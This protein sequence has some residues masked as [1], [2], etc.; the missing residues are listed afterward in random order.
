MSL[1][2]LSPFAQQFVSAISLL[3][4]VLTSSEPLWWTCRESSSRNSLL[5]I[6][7]GEKLKK[8]CLET[9]RIAFNF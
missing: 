4:F 9:S 5:H 7:E 6:A 8:R 3:I 2:G 1:P